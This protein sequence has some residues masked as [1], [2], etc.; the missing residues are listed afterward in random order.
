MTLDVLLASCASS[1]ERT[2]SVRSVSS[3][4]LFNFGTVCPWAAPLLNKFKTDLCTGARSLFVAPA[5]MS[6]LRLSGSQKTTRFVLPLQL[7]LVLSS[8]IPVFTTLRWKGVSFPLGLEIRLISL[9]WALLLSSRFHLLSVLRLCVPCISLGRLVR[10]HGLCWQTLLPLVTLLR[11][12][13]LSSVPSSTRSSLRSLWK[14]SSVGSSAVL[15]S[16]RCVHA[17]AHLHVC[18]GLWSLCG[19]GEMFHPC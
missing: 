13:M 8:G 3:P 15:L 12:S 16:S 4:L 7:V 9:L 11:I 2:T 5:A 10:L 18:K 17:R 6:I 14:V 19:R 1:L